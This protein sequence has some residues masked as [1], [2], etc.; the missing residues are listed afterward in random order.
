[1]NRKDPNYYRTV[2]W[3]R[4]FKRLRR[5]LR[6]RLGSPKAWDLAVAPGFTEPTGSPARGNWPVAPLTDSLQAVLERIIARFV[7]GLDGI[8]KANLPFLAYDF[9]SGQVRMETAMRLHTR[10]LRLLDPVY[11]RRVPPASDGLDTGGAAAPHGGKER[12]LFV[13]GA[14]PSIFHA[15]GLRL[16]DMIAEL[17]R[18]YDID[19]ATSYREKTDGSTRERLSRYLANE[20]CF[21]SRDFAPEAVAKLIQQWHGEQVPYRAIHFEWLD[22]A[23][24]MEPLRGYARMNIFTFMECDTR[25]IANDLAR[26]LDEGTPG[27]G[28]NLMDLIESAEA[29][30]EAVRQA[31]VCVCVSDSDRDYLASVFPGGCRYEV[32]TTGVSREFI[33]EPIQRHRDHQGQRADGPPNALFVGFF[34]SYTNLLCMEWYIRRIHPKVLSRVPDYRL[35]IVGRGDVSSLRRLRPGDRSIEFLG[36]VPDLSGPICEATVCLSPIISGAGFRGKIN[37]YSAAGVPTVSTRLGISGLSYVD[38]ESVL[39]ADA[40]GEFAEHVI[41]LLQ[42]SELRRRIAENAWGVV[43]EHYQWPRILSQ[44]K[45]IYSKPGATPAP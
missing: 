16:Y 21:S 3:S 35:R 22:T 7:P 43:E 28:R 26:G 6:F 1:M 15:G 11:E 29:E 4:P 37:Q 34:G 30:L 12:L 8:A 17:S 39:V 13:T 23:R 18:E 19:L 10:L 44:L 27:T 31:D 14:Y 40:P 5:Y 32:V 41:L 24:F 45:A 36:E 2:P 20:G 42:D 38:K 9:L 25:R 33:L